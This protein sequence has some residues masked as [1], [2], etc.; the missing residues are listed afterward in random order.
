MRLAVRKTRMRLDAYQQWVRDGLDAT[1]KSQSALARHLGVAPSAINRIVNGTRAVDTAEIAPIAA[2]LGAPP[3]N[4][5]IKASGVDLVPAKLAGKVAAGLFRETD[6]INQDEPDPV[7]VPADA[8]FPNARLLMFDV[9][10]DSMNELRPRAILDG[11]RILCVAYEDVAAEL[12]LR[13]GM[14]VVVQRTRDGGHLR[15]WSVKQLEVQDNKVVFHPRSTNPRHKPI[16]IDRSGFEAGPTE[17]EIIAI[18]RQILNSVP[19]A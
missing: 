13:D 9:E 2:F 11:D 4:V 12:P 14:T 18:V 8:R 7:F 16:V 6:D 19:L 1:G 5:E 17:V 10:G 3:P 15:E